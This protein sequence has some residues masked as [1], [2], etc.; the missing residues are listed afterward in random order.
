MILMEPIVH[1]LIPV[2]VVLA[3]FPKLD[4]RLVLV[5]SPLT[6]IADL[7]FLSGHRY[8]LHNVFFV[9]VIMAL[10]YLTFSARDFKFGAMTPVMITAFFMLSHLALDVGGPGVAA[11]YPVYGKF[12]NMESSVALDLGTVELSG[13]FLMS[14]KPISDVVMPMRAPVVTMTGVLLFLIA[15]LGLTVRVVVDYLDSYLKKDMYLKKDISHIKNH[16]LKEK[17]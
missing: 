8:L 6:V 12:I 13:K 17:Q 3:L 1:F 5:L 2:L 10:V 16:S 9:L 15:L 7:D 11:F 14:A 4:R